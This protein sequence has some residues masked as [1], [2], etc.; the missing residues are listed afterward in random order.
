MPHFYMEVYYDLLSGDVIIFHTISAWMI[1]KYKS[2]NINS[3]K[4]RLC[5]TGKSYM[6]MRKVVRVFEKSRTCFLERSYVFSWILPPKTI[7]HAKIYK[8]LHL[9]EML[10]EKA[11]L[12]VEST[13][14]YSFYTFRLFVFSSWQVQCFT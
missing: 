13:G 3:L 1:Q 5:F 9:N 14:K 6:F 8:K 7:A 4:I 2:L 11:L 12:F 10:N